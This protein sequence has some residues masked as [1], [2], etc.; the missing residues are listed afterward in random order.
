M[1]FSKAHDD[2]ACG[3]TCDSNGWVPS[4]YTRVHR[5]YEIIQAM[6]DWMGLPKVTDPTALG[7]PAH[8]GPSSHEE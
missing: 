2:S 6:R 7:L 5:D 4:V 8:C 1:P 3:Y